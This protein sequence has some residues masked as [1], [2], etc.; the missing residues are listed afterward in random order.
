MGI[1]RGPDLAQVL[2]AR[3]QRVVAARATMARTWRSR[4]V[5]LLGRRT[6]ADGEALILPGCRS[7]HTW[8]MQFPID[9]IFIDSAWRIVKVRERLGPWHLVCPV[10]GAWGVIE[11]AP[12]TIQQFALAAGEELRLVTPGLTNA[13]PIK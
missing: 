3:T 2:V 10:R 9:V 13:R 12:G 6:I 1:A 8:G 11:T 5:G 4:M 7:I